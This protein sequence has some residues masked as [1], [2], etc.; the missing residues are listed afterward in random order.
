MRMARPMAFFIAR[1][2]PMRLL[3]LRGDV[4]GDELRVRVGGADL[5][6]GESDRLADH[7]LDG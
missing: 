5:D 6:D 7:L 4:L 1:R 2:K 3:E